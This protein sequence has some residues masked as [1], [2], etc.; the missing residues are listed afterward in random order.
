VRFSAALPLP[1]GERVGAL[2]PLRCIR[3]P[4]GQSRIKSRATP[5]VAEPLLVVGAHLCATSLRS[6]T[7]PRCG[8]AQVRSCRVVTQA[9][10]RRIDSRSALCRSSPCTR[11]TY[12]AV[13]PGVAVAHKVRSHRQAGMSEAARQS[14]SPH[15][16]LPLMHLPLLNQLPPHIRQRINRRQQLAPQRRERILRGWRRGIEQ[17]SRH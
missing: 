9:C 1:C 10:G 6:G 16:H 15:C 8:R 5:G 3:G 13:D 7:P 11:Q 4:R 12:G 17:A 14:T 2:P